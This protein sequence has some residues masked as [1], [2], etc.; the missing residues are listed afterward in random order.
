[1]S[2][3]SVVDRFGPYHGA[4]KGNKWTIKQPLATMWS[5]GFVAERKLQTNFE[6]QTKN[7]FALSYLTANSFA[8][9]SAFAEISADSLIHLLIFGWQIE[10]ARPLQYRE[11]VVL[12]D[13][14]LL[15]S[16]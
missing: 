7:R 15:A 4:T 14:E 1:V 11:M 16:T 8:D 3:L 9:R 12:K 6:L 10:T 5:S 2:R 13:E